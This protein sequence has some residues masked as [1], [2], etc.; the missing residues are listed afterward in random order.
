MAYQV[1]KEIGAACAVLSG[2]VDAIILTCGIAYNKAMTELI[3][4]RVNRFAPVKVYPG[5]FESEAL[6]NGALRV[7]RGEEEEQIYI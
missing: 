4:A 5:E 7:L 1:G 2:Y 3:K 6:V